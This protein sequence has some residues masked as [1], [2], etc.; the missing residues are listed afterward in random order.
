ML[1]LEK[2]TMWFL[3]FWWFAVEFGLSFEIARQAL[4]HLSHISRLVIP[5]W[6]GLVFWWDW[7]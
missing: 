3:F 2:D 4:Y 6:F 7:I 5:V 1:I